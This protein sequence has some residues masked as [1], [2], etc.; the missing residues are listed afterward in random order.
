MHH[1]VPS[2]A[3]MRIRQAAE[4]VPDNAFVWYRKALC[5]RALDLDDAARK[6]LKRCLELAST[7]AD[8]N[9]ALAELDNQGWS[10]R[11]ALGRLLRRE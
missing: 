8:A 5:E 2:K 11:R 3:L 4:L 1:G 9:R 7:N 10:W 6:S